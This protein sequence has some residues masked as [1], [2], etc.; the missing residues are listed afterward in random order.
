M[1]LS[2]IQPKEVSCD[3][4]HPGTGQKIG[5]RFNVM[6]LIDDRMVAIR[7]KLSDKM[8]TKQQKKKI[9]NTSEIDQNRLELLFSACTGWEWTKDEN[10][11]VAD[12]NGDVPDFN[13]KNVM[14]VFKVC[15]WIPTQLD[16]F[17]GEDARF[18][19]D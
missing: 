14:E 1:D 13:N 15:P 18:F 11:E 12:W 10:G 19:Q 4:E 7:H 17:I 3:I 2:K 8:L 16:E 6:S 9:I 5:L